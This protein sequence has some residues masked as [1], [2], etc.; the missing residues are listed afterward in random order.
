MPPARIHRLLGFLVFATAC[1][2]PAPQ[3]PVPL[4][5]SGTGLDASTVSDASN[6]GDGGNRQDA[7]SGQLCAK[8]T[9][10]SG[11]EGLVT[12]GTVYI[13]PGDEIILLQDGDAGISYRVM[14]ATDS[15]DGGAHVISGA[16]DQ[17][18]SDGDALSISV[19]STASSTDV[20]FDYELGGLRAGGADASEPPSGVAMLHGNEALHACAAIAR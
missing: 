15:A 12:T 4:A 8:L 5:D 2:S 6:V 16:Y 9:M 14:I 17:R 11:V 7:A 10:V 3:P 18:P 20:R 13:L 1:S 19:T